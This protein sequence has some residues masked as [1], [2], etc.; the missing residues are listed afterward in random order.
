[1]NLKASS[2][3]FLL[4]AAVVCH[5]CLRYFLGDFQG[6]L[7][8]AVNGHDYG[9][10]HIKGGTVWVSGHR[11]THLY[12][13]ASICALASLVALAFAVGHAYRAFVPKSPHVV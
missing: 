6:F 4:L 1:M 10:A 5:F 7:T 8:V 12:G 3:L 9:F 11:L 13:V 2:L